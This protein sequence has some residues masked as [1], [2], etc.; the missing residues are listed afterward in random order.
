MSISA[1]QATQIAAEIE[2]L[3]TITKN[4]CAKLNGETAATDADPEIGA[5]LKQDEALRE[6]GDAGVVVAAFKRVA[7]LA[8]QAAAGVVSDEAIKKAEPLPEVPPMPPAEPQ[9]PVA[10]STPVPVTPMGIIPPS[11]SAAEQPVP[12]LTPSDPAPA[13]DPAQ[14]EAPPVS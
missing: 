4:Y 12:A 13:A 6:Q 7:T 5:A 8:S 11:V 10:E 2:R 14:P 3:C 1:T 9:A